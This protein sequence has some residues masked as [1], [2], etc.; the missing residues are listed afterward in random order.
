M[1]LCAVNLSTE[2]ILFYEEN[3]IQIYTSLCIYYLY[4]LLFKISLNQSTFHLS[5]ITK[6]KTNSLSYKKVG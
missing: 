3:N 2:L 6:G 5:R 4:I 1:Q